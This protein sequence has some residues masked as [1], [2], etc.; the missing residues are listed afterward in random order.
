MCKDS[1]YVFE[2]F[3]GVDVHLVKEIYHAGDSVRQ[4]VCFEKRKFLSFDFI[5]EM[6]WIRSDK[7]F[8]VPS[9]IIGISSIRHAADS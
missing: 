6:P 7:N 4:F 1:R 3:S 9:I 8:F 5:S 2:L